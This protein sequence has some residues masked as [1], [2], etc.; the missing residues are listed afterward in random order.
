MVKGL[1]HAAQTHPPLQ[2]RVDGGGRI[3]EQED[4]GEPLCPPQ[5][6]DSLRNHFVPHNLNGIQM[7]APRP[8]RKPRIS[9]KKM[10]P[11]IDRTLHSKPRGAKH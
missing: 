1:L 6:R 4:C 8:G 2:D 3:A 7:H 5:G 9:R 10:D 11:V